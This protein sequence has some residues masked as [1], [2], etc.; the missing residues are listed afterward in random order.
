MKSTIMDELNKSLKLG[1]ESDETF[2]AEDLPTNELVSEGDMGSA[3]SIEDIAE[4]QATAEIEDE[5]EE[6]NDASEAVED[7]AVVVEHAQNNLQKLTP[8]EAIALKKTFMQITKGRYKNPESLL[9]ARESHHASD[10]ENLTL[11]HESL[12]ETGKDLVKR[13]IEEIKKLFG[14]LK[15]FISKLVDKYGFLERRFQAIYRQASTML[16]SG[17]GQ[18]RDLDNGSEGESTSSGNNPKVTVKAKYLAINGKVNPEIVRSTIG[19]LSDLSTYIYNYG[20]KLLGREVSVKDDLE[21]TENRIFESISERTRELVDFVGKLQHMSVEEGNNPLQMEFF[22]HLPGDFAIG[23][24]KI[25]D[26]LIVPVVANI[27]GA[28]KSESNHANI[29]VATPDEAKV[30]AKHAIEGIRT[31]KAHTHSLVR[32]MKTH[33]ILERMLKNANVD[34]DDKDRK[35]H[36]KLA[37]SGETTKKLVKF[38][39]ALTKFMQQSNA[40]LY[41]FYN[42]AAEYYEQSLKANTAIEG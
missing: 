40:Y 27:K 16:E 34:N 14:R 6:F 39:G 2:N 33:L 1:T 11:V 35:D 23:G 17:S 32:D 28:E 41:D 31:V 36:Q 30:T 13:A 3:H 20:E 22:A 10:F 37:T 9:P 24:K 18:M 21:T 12:V 19:G 42:A 25:E 29:L 7:L 26:N 8:I 38:A 5:A 4:D 15:D